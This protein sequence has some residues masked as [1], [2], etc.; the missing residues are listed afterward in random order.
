MDM[1]VIQRSFWIVRAKQ[2]PTERQ[3]KNEENSSLEKPEP[4]QGGRRW[5]LSLDWRIGSFFEMPKLFPPNP[6]SFISGLCLQIFGQFVFLIFTQLPT[7]SLTDL[8]CRCISYKGLG[9]PSKTSL[10]VTED[11]K[12]NIWSPNRAVNEQ[13]RDVG[14]QKKSIINP[15]LCHL[16]LHHHDALHKEAFFETLLINHQTVLLWFLCL[17]VCLFVAFAHLP[18]MRKLSYRHPPVIK[19]VQELCPAPDVIVPPGVIFQQ[20]H[21]YKAKSPAV[22]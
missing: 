12:W 13:L 20:S 15:L 11:M 8:Y 2:N 14:R 18:C 4:W 3:G 22:H 10:M 16:I 21:P 19:S 7:R 17:F 5:L 9:N 6:L 1:K